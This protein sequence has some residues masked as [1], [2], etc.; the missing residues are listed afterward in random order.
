MLDEMD[1]QMQDIQKDIKAVQDRQKHYADAK[2]SLRT[3]D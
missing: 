1:H 3:F 2:R